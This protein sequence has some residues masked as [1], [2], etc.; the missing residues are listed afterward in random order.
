MFRMPKFYI[1]HR[2]PLQPRSHASAFSMLLGFAIAG[3]TTVASGPGANA[4]NDRL[5]NGIQF[6]QGSSRIIFFAAPGASVDVA[7]DVVNGSGTHLYSNTYTASPDASFNAT[8][9][10]RT[11][12]PW[13]QGGKIAYSVSVGGLASNDHVMYD[14]YDHG[15]SR[16]HYGGGEFWYDGHPVEFVDP[17]S[18]IN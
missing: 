7:V 13:A 3:C 15:V 2:W 1:K 9:D 4:V 8:V 12:K 5:M 6:P 18:S 16:M 14:I 10:P 17:A 11:N